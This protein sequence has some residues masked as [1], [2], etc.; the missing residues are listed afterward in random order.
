M[1]LDEF[2]T[3]LTGKEGFV[4]ST[5]KE[6][7]VILDR[8]STKG[9]SPKTKTFNLNYDEILQSV[10][11]VNLLAD[12]G[13]ILGFIPNEFKINSITVNGH[14]F[15]PSDYRNSINVIDKANATQRILNL[16]GE[17]TISVDFG[18]PIGAGVVS[19]DAEISAFLIINGNKSFLPTLPSG[20]QLTKDLDKFFGKVKD[21]SFWFLFLIVIAIVAISAVIIKVK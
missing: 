12:Q 5:D 3:S 6:T 21:A 2:S 16:K 20:I 9:G 17:N 13:R 15:H 14:I 19:P 18:A 7:I 10:L 11:K 4:S 8:E 1:S